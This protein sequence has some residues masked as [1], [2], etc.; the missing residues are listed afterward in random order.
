MSSS[1]I[2]GYPDI[3]KSIT[4]INVKPQDAL[5]FN[6]PMSFI[7][8]IKT[9]STSF[10]PSNLQKYYNG[11]LKKWNSFKNNKNIS[12]NDLIKQNYLEFLKE[13]SLNYT[14]IEERKFLS[15][16]D[17]ENPSDLQIAIPFYSRKLIEISKY[18]NKKREQSKFE[19]TKKK[20]VGTKVGLEKAI[21]DFTIDYLESLQDGSFYFNI[22]DVKSKL[23][24]EIEE[25]YDTYPKYFNQIPD[26]KIYDKKDLDWGL[27]IFLRTNS[28]ILSS[29]LSGYD[30]SA[31]ELKELD[32][33]IDNKRNL[34]KK[35]LS[36][37]FYYISTGPLLSG[38]TEVNFVSGKLFDSGKGGKNILNVNYPTT[39]STRED[40]L[41]TPREI[42]FFR[43]S[44]NAIIIIDGKT[45]SYTINTT[46]LEEN[47]LY[48]FP[49][50]TI[51]TSEFVV[52]VV[53][54]TYLKN[55]ITAGSAK[56]QPIQ[57]DDAVSY[58]GYVS[59]DD[60][61]NI[62]D[63]SMLF[64][65]GYFHDLKKDTFGNSFGL[66]KDNYNFRENLK[67]I[68]YPITKSLLL[69]GHSFYDDLYGE[70]YNFDYTFSDYDVAAGST[71]RSGLSTFTNSFV[72]LENQYLLYFR[73]F[74]PYE[75]LIDPPIAIDNTT[76]WECS[77]FIKSNGIPYIDSISSD[78][79][80]F[81]GNGTYY[82]SDLIEC[83]IHKEVPLTRALKDNLYP[84]ISADFTE[85]SRSIPELDCGLFADLINV[86]FLVNREEYAFINETTETTIVSSISS[87]IQSIF[88]RHELN[89]KIYVNNISTGLSYYSTDIF[90]YWFSK[91]PSEFITQL[92]GDVHSFDLS[93]NTIFIETSNYLM[94]DKVQYTNGVFENPKTESIIINHSSDTFDKISNRFKINE[95]VYYCKMQI[96]SSISVSNNIVIYP[97]IYKF[98]TIN[99][100]QT[101][102]FPISESQITNNSNYY[103]ISAG[104]VRYT[105]ID[106][107]IITYSSRNNILNISFL[108]KDQNEYI[109][110][111]EYDFDINS[112]MM[113][114]NHS[115]YFD[116][117]AIYS[118]IFNESWS[119]SLNVKLSSTVP[120]TLNEELIL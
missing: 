51:H 28:D 96:I 92:N 23:E 113:L 100:K 103:T 56:N 4:N 18:Y 40:Y 107:P 42:G 50:P 102:V 32:D 19:L 110:I 55:N 98:D 105:H 45:L 30:S 94:I 44:K 115:Q 21:A 86:P 101:V 48:Y 74:T 85:S 63:M 57:T 10:E 26:E 91:F 41:L 65:M 84:T 67:N 2:F 71:K 66:I 1:V 73:R 39:A 9:I 89:G 22:E 12:D 108:L 117:T 25:L 83:G 90:N 116:K 43:P 99:F 106:N 68:D 38:S 60:I 79:S 75:E 6:E 88:D 53:D 69:N 114:L 76:L 29:T 52:Y 61:N 54:D 81:P 118:N 93:N 82:F 8:F 15:N 62:P 87:T 34:T 109:S 36:T 3:P 17:F 16:I 77:G 35:Y 33:L 95:N 11:Y 5:D 120:I 31:I 97:I 46:V 119:S 70:G 78:L 111:Q 104:D 80:A 112:N 49:D 59:N 47:K 13:I 20:V 7:L 58:Q 37:D 72:E 64:N 24:V 14:N 27:D